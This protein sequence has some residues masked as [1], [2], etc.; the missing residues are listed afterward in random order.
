MYLAHFSEDTEIQWSKDS[1]KA[2]IA[3]MKED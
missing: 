2:F 3:G 1:P